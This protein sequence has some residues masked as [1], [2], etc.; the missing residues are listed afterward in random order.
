MYLKYFIKKI[1]RER[2]VGKQ[3]LAE[4]FEK[5][6][7]KFLTN[8]KNEKHEK[9]F[10]FPEIYM[11]KSEGISITYKEGIY[12]DLSPGYEKNHNISQTFYDQKPYI[13]RR[14]KEMQS[15]FSSLQG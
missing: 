4:I 2:I 11:E 3:D 7:S 5:A 8:L 10:I 12:K 13:V 15:L 1:V 6:N 14:W 9:Q